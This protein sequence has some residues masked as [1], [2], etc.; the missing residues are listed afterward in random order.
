LLSN[1][2][3]INAKNKEKLNALEISCRKGYFEMAKTIIHNLDSNYDI[4]VT[5]GPQSLLHMASTEGA[6]EVVGLLLSL[7]A[8]IDSL[9]ENGKN[10]LDIAIDFGY[11]DVIRVL[12][13]D[14]HWTKLFDNST[15]ENLDKKKSFYLSCK[16]SDYIF[17]RQIDKMTDKKMWDMIK[18]VLDNCH[19][20][21][22]V[23]NSSKFN[24]SFDFRVLDSPSFK[25]L[26]SHPLIKIANSGQEQLLVHETIRTLLDLKWR[27]IPRI[28]YYFNLLIHLA[29]LIMFT[30]FSLELLDLKKLPENNNKIT[31]DDNYDS[32][33]D[34]YLIAILSI[35]IFKMLIKIILA[36]IFAFFLRV[37]TLLEIVYVVLAFLAL[38]NDDLKFKIN[39][40]TI[41]LITMYFHYALLI[42]K[43]RYFGAYV[44]AF[45][46]TIKNCI[47]FF[48]VF[49][50][51]FLGF[52]FSFRI[53]TTTSDLSYFNGTTRDSL[54]TGINFYS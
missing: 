36:G 4:N 14:I 8:Q 5:D 43:L 18:I 40:C 10:C 33:L 54:I 22:D 25:N 11:E 46:G 34:K 50:L 42:Q 38:Q 45:K 15:G 19:L 52:V 7:G 27:K 39:Y 3:N 37:E 17:D 29:F 47:K 32:K 24:S 49:F 1:G 31:D 23:K 16:E 28:F 41:V 6:H 20:N 53:R 2:A 30:I 26:N 48:P 12:L 9:D 21:R 35:I 51:I 13:N 44:L